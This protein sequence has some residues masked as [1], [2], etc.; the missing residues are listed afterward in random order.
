MIEIRY[1][2]PR[3]LLFH[4]SQKREHGLLFNDLMQRYITCDKPSIY[5]KM[6]VLVIRLSLFLKYKILY[7]IGRQFAEWLRLAR[8]YGRRD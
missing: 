4:F 2:G 7:D 3:H 5:N 1:L 8:G 6:I